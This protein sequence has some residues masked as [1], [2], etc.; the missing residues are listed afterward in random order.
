MGDYA[1][2]DEGW[3]VTMLRNETVLITCRFSMAAMPRFFPKNCEVSSLLL[4]RQLS[5]GPGGKQ[6]AT[7]SLNRRPQFGEEA[8]FAVAMKDDLA[9]CTGGTAWNL[10]G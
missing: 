7:V 5:L 10:I 2:T 1:L 4:F 9:G 3:S 8:V 6:L